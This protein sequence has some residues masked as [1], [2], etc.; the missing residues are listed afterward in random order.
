[1]RGMAALLEILASSIRSAPWRFLSGAAL[2]ALTLAAGAG[3]LA[4]SGYLIAGSAIAGTGLMVF[5]TVIPSAAIRLFAIVRTGGRYAE[6]LATHDA[7]FRFIARLRVNVFQA[8]A[9]ARGELTRRRAGV[10]LARL[11]SD[12]DALDGLNIRFATPLSAAVLILAGFAIVLWGI[13][14]A[15]AVATIAPVLLGGVLVPCSIGIL[16]TREARRRMLALDVART[17]LA[18]LDRGR[19][20][21]CVAG[22]FAAHAEGVV[23]ACKSA[24]ETESRLI[25]LD[26]ALRL[27]ASLGSQGAILGALLTGAPLVASHIVAPLTFAAVVVFS[28]SLGEMVAPLRVTALD[29]GRWMLAAR[30]VQPLLG[31]HH[32]TMD[33]PS[34]YKLMNSPGAL[35]LD[36]VVFTFPGENE[37][38]VKDISLRVAQ[39]EWVALVGPSGGGKSTLLALAA[40]LLTSD[41]GTVALGGERLTR[42]GLAASGA[43][44]G[45]LLQRTELFRGSIADNLLLGRPDASD[46]ELQNALATLGLDR[47]IANLPKGLHHQLGDSGTGLSGG[48]RRRLGV[49]RLLVASPDVY[50]FDEATE[51]LDAATAALVIENIRSETRGRAVLLATHHRDE[52]EN[53]DVL[54]WIESGKLMQTARKGEAAFDAILDQLNPRSTENGN[55][56]PLKIERSESPREHCGKIAAAVV[57]SAS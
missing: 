17:R 22:T 14:P 30:R 35:E 20:E 57:V 44:I 24:A 39:G 2:A 26:A 23:A 19:T 32:A 28:F 40:G 53:A 56:R 43:R 33:K 50:V 21:L 6:R 31:H 29:I 46:D 49:A 8:I 42:P 1:M 16:A 41:R 51:G 25:R 47:V 3:L 11:S 7:A 37:P 4:L 5:D 13:S 45:Y 27:A 55:Y 10:L 48:E 54:L 36:D 34:K 12:L 18:D 52:A 15:L 38:V 9:D